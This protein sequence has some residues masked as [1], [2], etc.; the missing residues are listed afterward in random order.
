MTRQ[1]ANREL[2]KILEQTIESQPDIRF[3]QALRNAGFVKEVVF[4]SPSSRWENV[5]YWQ[6]EFNLEPQVLLTRVQKGT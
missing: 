1:E 3:S 5:I 2:L 6:D 4:E